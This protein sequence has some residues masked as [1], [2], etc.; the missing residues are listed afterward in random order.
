MSLNEQLAKGIIGQPQPV[1]TVTT[2]E[3]VR[4]AS[5]MLAEK[6]RFTLLIISRHLDKSVYNSGEFI[7]AVLPFIKNKR[8][9]LRILVG[10]S[11]PLVKEAH[12]LAELSI[13][14]SSKVEIRTL[15]SRDC[16]YNEAWMLADTAALLHLADA[17]QY[18]GNIDFYTPRRAQELTER[19]DRFWEDSRAIPELRALKL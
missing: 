13:A 5:R 2:R 8:S 6:T 19:F 9:S 18:H 17:S 12:R 7:D 11:R 1:I 14:L 4:L 3:D 16:D 10:E 15:G